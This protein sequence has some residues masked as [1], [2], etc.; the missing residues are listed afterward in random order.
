M[1]KGSFWKQIS[2]GA[3]ATALSDPSYRAVCFI[4]V[5]RRAAYIWS[6]DLLYLILQYRATLPKAVIAQS[7]QQLGYGMNDWVIRVRFPAGTRVFTSSGWSLGITWLLSQVN[8][9]GALSR[10]ITSIQCRFELCV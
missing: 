8:A 10:L 9:S 1:R 6:A 7:V 4:L 5:N 2:F 3:L